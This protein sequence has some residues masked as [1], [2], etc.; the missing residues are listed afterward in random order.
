VRL[1]CT[2]EKGGS[3]S[4]KRRKADRE[5]PELARIVY[6]PLELDS[7]IA[8]RRA[9]P[10]ADGQGRRFSDRCERTPDMFARRER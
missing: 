3:V 10:H 1:L 7:S 8:D 4:P 5:P 2:P 9:A 6:P